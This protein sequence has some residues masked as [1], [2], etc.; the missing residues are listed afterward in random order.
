[1]KL[2]DLLSRKRPAILAQWFEEALRVYPAGSQ[3]FFREEM[4]GFGN[5]VG[6]T[7]RESL[8]GLYEELLR[9][10]EKEN[11]L[12][13]LDPL[14]RMR[15]V[16]QCSPSQAVSFIFSL[17]KIVQE[18]LTREIRGHPLL[19]EFQDFAGEVDRLTLFAFDLYMSCREKVHE[20]KV[21]ELKNAVH[22]RKN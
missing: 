15:A 13:L 1:M 4:N 20:M 19:E 2:K 14:I 16:Q 6:S 21:K 12:P 5:P 9:G 3:G 10:W 22:L 8:G 11:I 18:E 17:K 7:I